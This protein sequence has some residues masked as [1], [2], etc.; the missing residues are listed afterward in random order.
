MSA[1]RIAMWSGPRNIST[2]MMRAWENREDCVVSDEPLYAAYLA[3]TG[4]DHPGRDEV[5]AAGE[6][7]W[8]QV[9]Q[10]LTGPVPGNTPLWYQKHMS[11]H[12]LPGMDRDWIHG[13]INVFL[14]RDPAEVVASYL[15]SRA[16]VA[17]EDIGL[18][19]QVELYDALADAGTPPPVIDAGDFLRDPE[20]HLRALCGLLGIGFTQ[21]ML[22]WPAGPR[23]S[24]GVWAP[25]WYDAVWKST[26]FERPQS[27]DTHL[28]GHAREVAEACRP[29]YERLHALR[30]RP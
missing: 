12:L 6:S 9:A 25:Y 5:I 11:H 1:L 30:L 23:D 4:L 8:R 20:A 21:R 28:T 17:P 10:T 14:I 2:A 19:Q 24:D 18:L 27:R 15:R 7:D 22:H 3:M 29:A 13:L 16:T 26:G